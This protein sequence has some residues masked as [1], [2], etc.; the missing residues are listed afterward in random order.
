MSRGREQF[1]SGAKIMQNQQLHNHK[2]DTQS[3]SSSDTDV[4]LLVAKPALPQCNIM[5]RNPSIS[6]A[7]NLSSIVNIIYESFKYC[8][9]RIDK[10][11]ASWKMQEILT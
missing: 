4:S 5:I 10:N 2:Y 11:L 8:N 9:I 3:S 6:V 1:P 7:R